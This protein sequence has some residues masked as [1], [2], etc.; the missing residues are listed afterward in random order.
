MKSLPLLTADVA[1]VWAIIFQFDNGT[2]ILNTK[3]ITKCCVK[4]AATSVSEWRDEPLL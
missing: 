4:V 3:I 1:L 2:F